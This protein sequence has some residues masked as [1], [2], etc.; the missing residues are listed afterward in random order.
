MIKILFKETLS[1]PVFNCDLCGD[2]IGDIS[3]GAALFADVSKR[4]ENAKIEVMHVHKGKCHELAEEKM[5][6]KCEWQPL[7]AHLYFLCANIEVD[8]KQLDK[9]KRIH[10][11][12]TA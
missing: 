9:L 7:G 10:G 1:C 2:M 3:E 12:R 6:R 11:T 4:R 5:H 8:S